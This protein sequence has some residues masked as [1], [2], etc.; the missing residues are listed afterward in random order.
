MTPPCP[1]PCP[2]DVMCLTVYTLARGKVLHGF[3]ISTVAERLG[4]TL[5]RAEEMAE[6]AAGLARHQSVLIL[7]GKGRIAGPSSSRR[8]RTSAG[9]HRPARLSVPQATRRALWR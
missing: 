7:T 1:S 9:R 3:M 6:A 2:A 5:E 4:I 8:A